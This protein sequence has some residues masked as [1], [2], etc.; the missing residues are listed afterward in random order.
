MQ[1]ST[2]AQLLLTLTLVQRQQGRL[3]AAQDSLDRCFTIC[4]DRDLV[5]IRVNALGEQAELHAANGRFMLAYHLHRT[6]HEEAMSLS[7]WQQEAKAQ[8]QQ[9]MMETEEARNEARRFREQARTDALTGLKNR[10]YVDEELQRL[11]DAAERENVPMG[12]AILDVDHFKRINDTLSHDVGDKVIRA[13]ADV[14]DRAMAEL[15]PGPDRST[16][17]F[18]ARLGGEEYLVVLTDREPEQL[19]DF[20]ESVRESVATFPWSEI[21][22]SLPVTVSGGLAMA[23]SGDTQGS[24]LRWADRALYEAKNSGRNRVVVADRAVAVE[25]S[26]EDGDIGGIRISVPEQTSQSEMR[27]GHGRCRR[28]HGRQTGYDTVDLSAVA[29]MRKDRSFPREY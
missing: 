21:T 3:V 27:D 6:Y 20:I 4:M 24:L 12:A 11:L 14:I 1:P 13:I 16:S 29:W 9:V 5:A 23:E 28:R 18:A 22:G 8:A 2:P 10:R 25:P 7:S 17:D 19:R 15:V 26:I